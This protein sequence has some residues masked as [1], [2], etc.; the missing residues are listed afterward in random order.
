QNQQWKLV[1]SKEKQFPQIDLVTRVDLPKE[2]QLYSLKETSFKRGVYNVKSS[3]KKVIEIPTAYGVKKFYIEESSNFSKELAAKYPNIKSFSGT[4]VENPSIKVEFSVGLDG[5]HFSIL[6]PGKPIFYV[7]SYTKDSQKLIA[8]RRSDL[9]KSIKDFTCGVK[10]SSSKPATILRR[11]TS[12]G[13]LR[14]YRLALACTGEYAKYHLTRLGIPDRATELEKKAAVLSSMNTTIT[15]VNSIYER[16]FSV[17]LVFVANDD[18]LIF[19]DPATDNLTNNNP[20]ILIDES[21]ALCDRVIGDAKYDIGHTFSRGN[22]GFA[23]HGVCLTGFK[24][25][26][27]TGTSKPFGDTFDIDYVCHEIGHQFGATH[28]F[29]GTAG[30][31]AGVNRNNPTAVE[32]GSGSTIM[33]YA[34]TCSPQNVQKNSDAHFHSVSIA[35][36]WD[37]ITTSANSAN[38]ATETAT[39]DLAPTADAGADYSIPKSTPFI[40]K[41]TGFDPDVG[42]VL[43]YS[44]EEIDNEVGFTIPP[45]AANTGG[46]MFRS[47]PLSTSPNRYMPTLA[48][49]ISGSTA[50]KWQVLPS[51]TRALNFSLV[52][53][54]NHDSG[55]ST[56]R[57]DMLVTV[58]PAAAFTVTSQ[59]IQTAW[60]VG[61][62]QTITWNVGTTNVTPINCQN[63]TIKLSTDGGVTFPITLANNT[64]NDGTQEI[65][66]P[67]NITTTARIMVAAADNI[68]YNVN[69]SNFLIIPPAPTF[70]FTDTSGE[71]SSCNTEAGSVSYNLNFDFINGLS[72]AVTL[73]ATGQPAG[74]TVSF[75]PA[76]IS[77]DGTVTMTI[78]N[79]DGK[80]AKAYTINIVAAATNITRNVDVDLNLKSAIFSPLVLVTPSNNAVDVPFSQVF[81]WN[82]EPNALTYNLEIAMDATFSDILLSTNTRATSFVTNKISSGKKYYW[83]VKP[84]NNCGEGSF[85]MVASFTTEVCKVC[86]SAGNTNFDTGTTL[87]QFNTIDN[88]TP[89]K[90][91]GYNDFTN[92]STTLQRNQTYNLTINTT[93]DLATKTIVWIDWN[94]NC[95]F[96]DVGEKYSVETSASTQNGSTTLSPIAITIPSD[97]VLGNTFM[98]VTTKYAKDGAPTSCENGA[99]AEVE[100]YTLK[101]DKIASLRDRTFTHF[102]LFPNPTKGSFRLKFDVVDSEN[103]NLQLFDITGRLIG[104]KKYTIQGKVFFKEISFKNTSKGLYL[105]RVINGTKQTTRKFIIY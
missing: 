2:Y 74:A 24:A 101:I 80:T 87:V 28:T 62:N 44:W 90:T 69:T 49:V 36:M 12:D 55:G 88:A 14:T 11:N 67:N 60:N 19:L 89:T 7:D 10:D 52:V 32:P 82:T 85:S 95:S 77:K 4:M 16:D 39:G 21:Q 59:N 47:L 37:Y 96:N 18:Q 23:K 25:S 73:S 17:K 104:S 42:D 64:P 70:L 38:C 76:T 20:N 78:S 34:G 30:N 58:T 91:K 22:K 51:V 92:I 43:T 93:T 84:L 26:G 45:V 72:E 29:N 3:K 46:A 66:V 48:T 83:R 8:Y 57:D 75:N 63:V 35:E 94:Q 71:Q 15:R 81:T 50:S 27:I 98:R 41:G 5:Y 6:E 102:N 97:A 1:S 40:L 105:L 99:N 9:T 53:R 33:A 13:L 61:S 100:D 79:L 56:A 54:D 103:V 86:A 31:C 65:V 68:F